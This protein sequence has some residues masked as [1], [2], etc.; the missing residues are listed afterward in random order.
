VDFAVYQLRIKDE[1][2]PFQVASSPGRNFFRNAA[3]TRHRGFEVSDQAKL[4]PA[5]EV[6]T[7]YTFSDFVFVDDGNSAQSFEGNKLPGIAPHHLFGRVTMRIKSWQIEPQ[8]EWNSKL[9][10]DDANTES[11]MNHSYAILHLQWRVAV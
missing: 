1:L 8:L 3:E 9:Y 5:I 2:V 10:V 4:T 11:A 6:A 7:S